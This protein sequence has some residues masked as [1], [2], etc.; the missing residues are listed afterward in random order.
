MLSKGIAESNNVMVRSLSERD[1]YDLLLQLPVSPE[2]RRESPRFLTEQLERASHLA[3]DFPADY[4]ELEHWLEQK[5]LSVGKHYATYLE[6][7]KQG[8]GRQYFRT[9]SHALSFLQKIAP[10]KLVDGAWLYGTVEYWQD[11][12]FHG[13]VRTYLEELGDGQASQNHVLLYQR[14]LAENECEPLPSL[15]DEH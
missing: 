2:A 1:M 15:S 6:K 13:L 10:T 5:T 8:E 11:P 3:H 4:R 9:N 7:R 14:L 12:R